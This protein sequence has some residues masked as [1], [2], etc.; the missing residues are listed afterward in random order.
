[1]PAT[2]TAYSV[3]EALGAVKNH[4]KT[5]RPPLMRGEVVALQKE[6]PNGVFAHLA[7]PDATAKIFVPTA[8][9]PPGGLQRGHHLEARTRL[10]QEQGQSSY[11]FTVAGPVRVLEDP[12]PVAQELLLAMENLEQE[13]LIDRDASRRFTDG[14]FEFD[15][16]GAVDLPEVKRVLVLTSE[17]TDG[18]RDFKKSLDHFYDPSVVSLRK[19]RTSGRGLVE[20]LPTAISEIGPDEADL[21]FIVRGGG[22]WASMR[23]F[24]DI[25]VA[26][27]IAEAKVPVATGVGHDSD[28]RLSDLVADWAFANP[29]AAAYALQRRLRSQRGAAAKSRGKSWRKRPAQAAAGSAETTPLQEQLRAT[30]KELMD[31]RRANKA[32][33]ELIDRLEQARVL[34]DNAAA[35]ARLELARERVRFRARWHT[36]AWIVVGFLLVGLAFF[37]GPWIGIG[38]AGA[39]AS[40]VCAAYAWRGSQRAERPLSVR[41][42]HRRPGSRQEWEVRIAQ[43]RTPRALR[44]LV[45]PPPPPATP[46][47]PPAAAHRPPRRS[48]ILEPW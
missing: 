27:A 5:V 46:N 23:E 39:I 26:R 32:A 18:W 19:V 24:D 22:P 28:T 2:G 8:Q 15:Q 47:L 41:A 34:A 37:G 3:S 20:D 6:G 12:G 44:P 10:Q 42:A 11:Y 40:W 14:T 9:L 31:T 48:S 13:E 33:R 29:T 45:N 36:V 7:G 17:T 38:G 30:G 1:M 16:P 43:A 35:R 4:L 21:V 25:R